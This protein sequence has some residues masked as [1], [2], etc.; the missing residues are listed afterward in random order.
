MQRMGPLVLQPQGPAQHGWEAIAPW[1]SGTEEGEVGS[2]GKASR[3]FL[4]LS[5]D[6]PCDLPQL[7]RP[8]EGHAVSAGVFREGN[9][10]GGT[11]VFPYTPS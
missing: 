1:G 5:S 8:A 2:G 11:H 6:L 10:P 9:R 4:S 7:L 3:D